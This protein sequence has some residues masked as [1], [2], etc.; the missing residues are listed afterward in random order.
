MTVFA[1][2]LWFVFLVGSGKCEWIELPQIS[3]KSVNLPPN[4]VTQLQ[5]YQ[6]FPYLE[7]ASSIPFTVLSQ[8]D[9]F[10]R[11]YSNQPPTSVT[12]ETNH[13]EDLLPSIKFNVQKE[14]LNVMKITTSTQAPFLAISNKIKVFATK[15]SPTVISDNVDRDALENYIKD[16]HRNK[17]PQ[18]S[19][20]K[21]SNETTP[22]ESEEFLN[23]SPVS[24]PPIEHKEVSEE[25]YASEEYMESAEKVKPPAQKSQRRIMKFIKRT[26]QPLSFSSFMR[27]L[28]DVQSSFMLKTV[29]NINDKILMLQDF[30]DNL[31]LNIQKKIKN[32]W[33]PKPKLVNKKNGGRVK[34]MM[35]GDHQNGGIDFPSAEGALLTI[36]FLTFAVFLI[37]LVLVS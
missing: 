24:V 18:S 14:N 1:L 22:E 37:K 19:D 7:T 2:I 15:D 3:P 30:R 27:F 12:A 16:L 28:K 32:L 8:S 36:S 9:V 17:E 35:M 20:H 11:I 31:M 34:R 21:Y 25:N 23:P 6:S 26:S 10:H 29:S 13:F 4:S 5:S 33:K